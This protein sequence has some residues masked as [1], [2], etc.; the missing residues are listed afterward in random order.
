[1]IKTCGCV[2]ALM[3]PGGSPPGRVQKPFVRPFF[4]IKKKWDFSELQKRMNLGKIDL[5]FLESI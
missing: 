5:I 3:S 4:V 1:M 2:F